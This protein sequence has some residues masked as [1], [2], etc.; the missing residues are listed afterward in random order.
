MSHMFTNCQNTNTGYHRCLL[1]LSS[2]NEA[3][4]QTCS[5]TKYI[6]SNSK[7]PALLSPTCGKYTHVLPTKWKYMQIKMSPPSLKKL[8]KC[9][10][11][12]KLIHDEKDWKLAENLTR[13]DTI[14]WKKSRKVDFFVIYPDKVTKTVYT[15]H[16]PSPNLLF[17][18]PMVWKRSR[19]CKIFEQTDLLKI[20]AHLKL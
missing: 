20:S 1:P 17:S 19:I 5:Q 3:N 15:Q 7:M 12:T 11:L 16:M 13:L 8:G 10:H 18:D 2:K 6:Y 4:E 9:C 14:Q